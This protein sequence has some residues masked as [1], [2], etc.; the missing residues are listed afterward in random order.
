MTLGVDVKTLTAIHHKYS[1]DPDYCLRDML[2]HYL[3]LPDSLT[4]GNL[5]KSLRHDS[6]Q[7]KDVADEIEGCF[8]GIV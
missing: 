7:C 5:C 1:S 2:V 3:Y 8:S 4:W 6:L